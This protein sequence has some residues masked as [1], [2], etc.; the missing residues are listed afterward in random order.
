VFLNFIKFFKNNCDLVFK[1]IVLFAFFKVCLVLNA[2]KFED[3]APIPLE[4]VGSVGDI[5]LDPDY[6]T[7]SL[8]EESPALLDSL[9]GVVFVNSFDDIVKEG[10][11]DLNIVIEDIP[12]LQNEV[13]KSRIIPLIGQPVN[14]KLLDEIT[15]EVV[16]H[17]R[18]NK[19]PVVDAIIPE[20]DI[21][22][23]TIQVLVL[24]SKLGQVIVENNRYFSQDLLLGKL[25]IKKGEELDS[26]ILKE[27][28]EW[29]NEN[30]FRQVDLVYSRGEN[31]QETDI[32][33]NVREKLPLRVYAGYENSGNE[34]TGLDRYLAGFNYGNV[35]GL[36]HTISYQYTTSS[37]LDRLTG[38]SI[39]YDIPISPTSKIN[40]LGSFAESHLMFEDSLGLDGRNWQLGLRYTKELRNLGP[41]EHSV[42]FG[43]DFKESK[44]EVI[45]SG[46][47]ADENTTHINNFVFGYYAKLSDPLGITSL[48]TNLFYS[49][50]NLTDK[51]NDL[52]FGG[53]TSN[54]NGS[55]ISFDPNSQAN[56]TYAKIGLDR[57]TRL[58]FSFIWNVRAEYLLTSTNLLPSEQLTLGG[59]NTVRGYQEAESNMDTGY[60]INTEI[61]AP[62]F[63]L[64]KMFK[65]KWNDELNLLSFFDYGSGRNKFKTEGAVNDW[66]M[67]SSG[68][69]MRYLVNPYFNMNMSWGYQ[70]KDSVLYPDDR[71]RAHISI[72][73]T[74]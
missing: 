55:A 73:L 5:Y 57:K 71:E 30:P 1:W 36:D 31:S 41:L 53:P 6:Y 17:F 46:F 66:E 12:I 21:Q 45:I 48:S 20:Q 23:G 56:Y 39:T 37:D 54:A 43:F 47:A 63:S 52:Q 8:N 58:P 49:P 65:S 51:N 70:L 10:R 38:N 62:G 34:A 67:Y 26:A 11:E 22:T 27:D 15:N 35:F 61:V 14:L 64:G 18:E 69:G 4:S 19:R 60:W 74:Y 42:N 40:I 2:Q 25:R 29:I 16:L 32:T 28:L 24:Q 9:N 13:F 33:L 3:I 7:S 68:L 59:S 44:S 50:G 72:S